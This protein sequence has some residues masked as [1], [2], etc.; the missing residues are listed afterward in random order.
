MTD[1][2]E[3]V[4]RA[5]FDV[6]CPEAVWDSQADVT[7]DLFHREARAAIAVVLEEADRTLRECWHAVVEKH[8]LAPGSIT[9][10]LAGATLSAIRALIPKERP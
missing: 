4:A 1:L 2:V 5:I 8:N 7:Q 6:D 9:E 10:E 3:R